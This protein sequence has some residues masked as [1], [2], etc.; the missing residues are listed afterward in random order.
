MLEARPLMDNRPD[1]CMY[2]CRC[3]ALLAYMTCS[4]LMCARKAW[5]QQLIIWRERLTLS[6]ADAR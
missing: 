6:K 4:C 5:E 1:G 3:M 2:T